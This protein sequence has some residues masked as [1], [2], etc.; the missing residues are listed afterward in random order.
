[1]TLQCKPQLKN[2]VITICLE[3]TIGSVLTEA[4]RNYEISLY[5]FEQFRRSSSR[6]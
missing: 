1:M 6:R 4:Y 2:L 3:I 5:L